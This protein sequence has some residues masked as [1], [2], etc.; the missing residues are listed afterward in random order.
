MAN[1]TVLF[2]IMDL[3]INDALEKVLANDDDY[4]KTQKQADIYSNQ[5]DALNLANETRLLIDRYASALNANSC[6]YGELAYVLG[7]SDCLELLLG[8]SHVPTLKKHPK[9]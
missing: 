9:I 5:M 6:R 3:R 4:Q 7:F 1:N 8:L 2:Q